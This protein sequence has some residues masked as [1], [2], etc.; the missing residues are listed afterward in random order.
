MPVLQG[1]FR[2]S[3]ILIYTNFSFDFLCLN[4]DL[5]EERGVQ[6]LIKCTLKKYYIETLWLLAVQLFLLALLDDGVPIVEEEKKKV[7]NIN[8]VLLDK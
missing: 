8:W 6:I 3:F 4:E 2:W 5:T 7:G 1:Q